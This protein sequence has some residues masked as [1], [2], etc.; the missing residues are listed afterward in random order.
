MSITHAQLSW[1]SLPSTS[2]DTYIYEVGY[3][4]VNN[5]LNCMWNQSIQPPNNITHINTTNGTVKLSGLKDDTCYMFGVRVYSEKTDNPEKWEIIFNRTLPLG[6]LCNHY[7]NVYNS[8]L[9]I[10]VVTNLSSTHQTSNAITLYWNP[11]IT[12]SDELV[13]Y[14]VGY[15]VIPNNTQCNDTNGTDRTVLSINSIFG[16]TTSDSIVVTGLEPD[17]CYVFGVQAYSIN[18]GEWNTL[19]LKTLPSEIIQMFSSFSVHSSSSVTVLLPDSMTGNNIG[20][21]ISG[22]SVTLILIITVSVV[23]TS[24]ILYFVLRYIIFNH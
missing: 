6:M 20:G 17:T 11:L 22:V 2:I 3:W 8:F 12:L 13:V 24:L 16:N 23:V 10:S 15:S 4:V 7:Y 5:S 1:N 18:Y 9:L 14:Q 21:I 19:M